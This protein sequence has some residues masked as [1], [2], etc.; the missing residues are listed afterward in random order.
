[1]E[2]LRSADATKAV[3]LA[4]VANAQMVV[5]RRVLTANVQAAQALGSVLMA[6]HLWE[7]PA[8][9]SH[10]VVGE[11]LGDGAGGAGGA[12]GISRETVGTG[13]G[14]G[15]AEE[16]RRGE[17]AVRC[18]QMREGYEVQARKLPELGSSTTGV[19]VRPGCTFQVAE[20][21]LEEGGLDDGAF[22]TWLRLASAGGGNA[23]TITQGARDGGGNAG[24]VS[25]TA[26]AASGTVNAATSRPNKNRPNSSTQHTPDADGL[27]WV[28]A[29][30]PV[31]GGLVCD[32]MVVAASQ[33][34]KAAHRPLIDLQCKVLDRLQAVVDA[35]E[36]NE[37]CIKGSLLEKVALVVR[38][39]QTP[40]AA[41]VGRN[42]AL[43]LKRM[44]RDVRVVSGWRKAVRALRGLP[45]AATS[46]PAV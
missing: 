36:S 3:P 29:R 35:S 38:S 27:G 15:V 25:G 46:S 44:Q 18:F 45:A 11:G 32:E 33:S 5:V 40:A 20:V 43:R 13:A 19:T 10:A 12:G 41:A 23:G 28:F 37:L 9:V 31:H 34:P 17:V 16:Q 22:Q 30:H 14:G 2:K 26:N 7:L 39:A 24:T 4:V 42:L 6:S 1:V 21:M 8:Q